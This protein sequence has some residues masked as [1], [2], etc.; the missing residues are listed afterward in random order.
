[1]SLAKFGPFA[2][3]WEVGGRTVP[4]H[5]ELLSLAGDGAQVVIHRV[6]LAMAEDDPTTWFGALLGDADWRPHLV[7]AIAVLLDED[8]R[9]D[10]SLLWSAMDAGSWVTPQLAVTACYADPDFVSRTRERVACRCPIRVPTGLTPAERHSATGPI[11]LPTRRAKMLVSLLTAGDE[12]P[13]LTP[14]LIA[15]RNE[16]DVREL[17]PASRNDDAQSIVTGWRTDLRQRFRERGVELRP[18]AVV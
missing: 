11:G 14:W 5:L 8:R 15:V 3:V 7:G 6:A 1:V 2:S 10:R 4:G 12:I 9:L 18:A 16:A 17:L 13:G